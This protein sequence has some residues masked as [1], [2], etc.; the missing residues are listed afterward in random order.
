MNTNAKM[1][2]NLLRLSTWDDADRQNAKAL[3][4]ATY[5]DAEAQ[6]ARRLVIRRLAG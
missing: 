1:L 4:D 6:D 5:D 3:V 2:A